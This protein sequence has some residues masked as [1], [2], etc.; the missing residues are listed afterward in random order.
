M[1]EDSPQQLNQE[2]PTTHTVKHKTVRQSEYFNRLD[3]KLPKEPT[4]ANG[5]L[6]A[7]VAGIT[8]MPLNFKSGKDELYLSLKQPRL[9]A[10]FQ[11]NKFEKIEAKV[12]LPDECITDLQLIINKVNVHAKKYWDGLTLKRDPLYNKQIQVKFPYS[13]QVVVDQRNTDE[14][15][16]DDEDEQ[17]EKTKMTPA[18]LNKFLTGKNLQVEFDIG[19]KLWFK[20]NEKVYGFYFTLQNVSTH[21]DQ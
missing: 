3:L 9:Y 4:K 5:N 21:G 2:C 14:E 8:T 20:L 17:E 12:I 19:V 1:S 13:G 11:P 18:Q 6:D 7:S 10:D 16:D 15:E